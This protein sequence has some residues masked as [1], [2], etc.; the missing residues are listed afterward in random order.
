MSNQTTKIMKQ[1]FISLLLLIAVTANSQTNVDSITIFLDGVINFEDVSVHE[2]NPII[3]VNELAPE[4]ADEV[5]EFTDENIGETFKKAQDFTHA[6]ITVDDHTLVLVTD[7]EN[8]KQSGAWGICMP[9][10]EGYI[11][12]GEMEK[13][14]DHIN[15]IIGLPND[16]IRTLYLFE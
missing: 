11:L 12:R 10:G 9:Y 16:A 13:L 15:N 5:L 3:T 14:E 4:Q 1:L 7:W 6:L 8:C 2:H